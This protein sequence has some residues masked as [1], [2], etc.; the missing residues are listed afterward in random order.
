MHAVLLM[1]VALALLA[2]PL[3]QAQRVVNQLQTS[4]LTERDQRRE[5][6]LEGDKSAFKFNFAQDGVR[7]PQQG[8]GHCAPERMT[9]PGR[10]GTR[11][12]H[13]S[14]HDSGTLPSTLQACQLGRM[15]CHRQTQQLFE[16]QH[17]TWRQVRW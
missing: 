8:I 17:K 7:S 2:A 11:A 4:R 16:P 9:P 14:E 15:V 13:S 1:A 12:V 6:P 3:A 10:G 5:F